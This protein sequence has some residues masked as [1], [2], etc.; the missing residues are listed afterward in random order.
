MRARTFPRSQ[1][2]LVEYAQTMDKSRV[3][4][5]FLVHGEL[6]QAQQLSQKL[7]EAGYSNIAIPARGDSV[8]IAA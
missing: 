7:K 8:E 5:T 1:D 4:Q 6:M 2:E 3:K